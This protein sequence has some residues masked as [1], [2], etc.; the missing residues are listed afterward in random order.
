LSTALP[1]RDSERPHNPNAVTG[2]TGLRGMAVL[3]M[4]VLDLVLTRF[5]G[6]TPVP[7]RLR[8]HSIREVKVLFMHTLSGMKPN[9][10]ASS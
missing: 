3:A 5:T 4:P 8:A 6:G 1:Y 9:V 2:E 10:T 7:V